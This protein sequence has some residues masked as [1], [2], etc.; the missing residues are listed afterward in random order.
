MS[1]PQFGNMN[2]IN[3]KNKNTVKKLGLVN[4][5]HTVLTNYYNYSSKGGQI[6]NSLEERCFFIK[7]IV[8]LSR[9]AFEPQLISG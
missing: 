9:M 6:T 3:A 8:F 5:V 2:L 4:F 7:R 1:N